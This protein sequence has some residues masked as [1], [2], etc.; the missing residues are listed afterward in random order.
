M[1]KMEK[2]IL[3][4]SLA[5][6]FL[7][8][9]AG[10]T[11]AGE[12]AEAEELNQCYEI[13]NTTE[14]SDEARE[15]QYKA[16]QAYT[17]LINSFKGAVKTSSGEDDPYL[18]RVDGMQA[19]D[20]P[21]YY[22]GAYVNIEGNLVIQIAY[23]K[24]ALRFNRAAE[25][26]RKI[27]GTEHLVFREAKH[28]YSELID[29]MSA[30]L[31]YCNSEKYQDSDVR[32]VGFG[33]SEDKNAITVSLDSED[34]AAAEAIEL[35]TG[36]KGLLIFEYQECSEELTYSLDCGSKI[37]MSTTS[38]GFSI[39]YPAFHTT[40]AGTKIKGF[41]TCGHA[42]DNISNAASIYCSNGYIGNLDTTRKQHSGSIDAA[43]ITLNGSQVT[44]NVRSTNISVVLTGYTAPAAG[45]TVYMTGKYSLHSS[46]L[47]QEVSYTS[48]A[49]NGNPELTDMVKAAYSSIPGD[50]GGI[51]YARVGYQNYYIA[52]VQ[53]RRATDGSY[54]VYCKVGNINTAFGISLN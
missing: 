46:G 36:K 48:P 45:C 22:G 44:T 34:P 12:K 14:M 39:G 49:S 6:V 29:T 47:A 52:G 21:A 50:S 20:F 37:G 41:V 4:C 30:L 11:S 31:K 23:R 42:F 25:Q 33:I 7:L 26:V 10:F 51:V 43:F 2:L 53:S 16:I 32:I 8:A 28:S 40:A 5:A 24:G 13:N 54:S 38:L 27:C 3:A 18:Y 17:A 19:K 15:N 9:A 1:K 35:S